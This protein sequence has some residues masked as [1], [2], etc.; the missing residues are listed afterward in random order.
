MSKRIINNTYHFGDHAVK[1]KS[2]STCHVKIKKDEEKKIIF[3]DILDSSNMELVRVQCSVKYIVV[4]FVENNNGY[5]YNKKTKTIERFTFDEFNIDSFGDDDK[6]AI[7]TTIRITE[8]E[9][10]NSKYS[11][12]YND[13]GIEKIIRSSIGDQLV[14]ITTFEDVNEKDIPIVIMDGIFMHRN[15]GLVYA[16]KSA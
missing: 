14:D 15:G 11:F 16:E 2:F 12:N 1:F 3:Y 8:Y 5:I 4:L 7:W 13:N 9:K 10:D 6:L